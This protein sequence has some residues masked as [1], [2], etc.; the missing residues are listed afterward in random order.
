M[1]TFPPSENKGV[2]EPQ[3]PQ[4]PALIPVNAVFQG[5]PV[6]LIMVDGVQMMPVVDI[7]RALKINRGTLTR[8]LGDKHLADKQRSCRVATPGGSQKMV[9]IT[10]LGAVGLLYKVDAEG[11]E[12][13]K[14]KEK[15]SDFQNWATNLVKDEMLV[16]TKLPVREAVPPTGQVGEVMRRHFEAAM[17]AH[18]VMGIPLALARSKAL[19]HAGNEL[20]MDLTGYAKLQIAD[21]IPQPRLPAPAAAAPVVIDF[22]KSAG[23]IANLLNR[24]DGGHLRGMHVNKYLKS[25][26][27]I[28]RNDEGRWCMTDLGSRY[29][30]LAPYVDPVNGHTG[31]H[32]RWHQAI[33]KDSGLIRD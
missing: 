7:G 4:T 23:E 10:S 25:H 12:D 2:A 15:I 11:I 31:Y 9:C 28:Y 24:R 1:I 14:L 27:Y 29:G 13:E 21:D 17:T 18:L 16:Q 33:L 26:G 5:I 30:K 8:S 6:R 3:P 20:N 19:W 22:Y 32:L